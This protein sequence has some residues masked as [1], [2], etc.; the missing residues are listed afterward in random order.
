VDADDG[1]LDGN[2]AAGAL[3]SIFAADVT[4]AL[5]KCASCGATRALAALHAYMRA[6]GIVLRCPSCDSV[7]LRLVQ[8]KAKSWLELRG[9]RYIEIELGE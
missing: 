1:R 2:A 4:T 3:G 5:G 7:Q 8:S 9:L 6:P